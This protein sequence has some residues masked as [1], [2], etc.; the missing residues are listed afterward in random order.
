VNGFP[1]NDLDLEGLR[2]CSRPCLSVPEPLSINSNKHAANLLGYGVIGNL[3]SSK[4]FFACRTF[5]EHSDVPSKLYA[6]IQRLPRRKPIAT[7]TGFMLFMN[8]LV[9]RSENHRKFRKEMNIE[10]V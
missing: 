6:K 7:I 5:R 4:F 2:I 1:R 9:V 10:A 3:G 8:K